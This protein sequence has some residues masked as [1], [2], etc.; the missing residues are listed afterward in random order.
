ME[1]KQMEGGKAGR[2][3]GKPMEGGKAGRMEGKP[4]SDVSVP[5]IVEGCPFVL[6]SGSSRLRED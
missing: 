2:M 3:E 5:P 6:F 4:T 1:G